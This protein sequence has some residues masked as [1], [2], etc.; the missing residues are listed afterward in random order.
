[1]VE[2]I[3]RI[4]PQDKEAEQAV[5][6]SV[7]LLQDAY[8]AATKF[9]TAED[10]YLHQHKVIFEAMSQLI[11]RNT[12]VDIRT[13]TDEL[14]KQHQLEDAGGISYLSDIAVIV[15]SPANAGYYAKI[16]AEKAARRRL[17]AASTETVQKAFDT[18][19]DVIDLIT[20]TE[21]TLMDIS[22]DTNQKDFQAIAEILGESMFQI[23]E[24]AKN[25]DVVT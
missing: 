1:M 2:H 18:N 22:Q 11:N 4:P 19:E 14:N 6:G 5:L 8:F 21:Q 15:P 25:H 16:V 10:F 7:F 12:P 3:E 20:V 23:E 17:I 9:I 13:I 24:N